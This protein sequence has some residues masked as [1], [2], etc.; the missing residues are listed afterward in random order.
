MRAGRAKSVGE[1][2]E[3]PLAHKPG[4]GYLALQVDVQ[5]PYKTYGGESGVETHNAA[6]RSHFRFPLAVTP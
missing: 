1:V 2:I 3:E 6:R 5:W 4:N